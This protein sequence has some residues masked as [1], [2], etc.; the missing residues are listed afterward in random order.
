MECVLVDL[1]TDRAWRWGDA[2]PYRLDSGSTR[3]IGG[4]WWPGAIDEPR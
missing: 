4:E 1:D 2:T 3:T